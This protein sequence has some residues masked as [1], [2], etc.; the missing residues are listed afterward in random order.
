MIIIFL[1]LGIAVII[2]IHELG[3]FLAAKFFKVRVEEFG[4]G[5]PPR[6]ASV[7]RGETRYSVNA[8]PFG[9]FV[10]LYGESSLDEIQTAPDRDR[11][12]LSQSARRRTA[13][14]AAGVI[15]NFILGW[16]LL[17]LVFSIG[18]PPALLI[19]GIA[20]GSPAAEAGILAGDIIQKFSAADDFIAAVNEN[21]GVVME[22]V[23][24]REGSG[25]EGEKR[26]T[27]E[28]RVLPPPG[29]GALGVIISETGIPKT[30]F[31][32]SVIKALT[33]S[34]AAVFEIL[35][36]LYQFIA[37]LFSGQGAAEQFVGP[38]GIFSVADQLSRLGPLYV[39][40]LLALISLNLSVLNILPIPALDGGR[41]LFM[42]I[43][44]IRG[45][46]IAPHR[47]SLAHAIGFIILILLMVT[48][49]VR[50]I[51]NLL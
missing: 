33:V 42:V 38:V 25:A 46:R 13:I 40:Q 8:L 17:S 39:I 45:V 9:G 50:D 20:P 19:S 44:K 43:E 23:I 15:M 12:F 7:T 14:I 3:H 26:F 36:A 51:T 31:P 34:G 18:S 28:P 41:L 47:E 48:L 21:K 4:F 5:F 29:E 35:K 22:I 11:G 32:G 1:I 27:V 37:G 30:P 49:T 2:V 10:R 16:F 24:R 6:L